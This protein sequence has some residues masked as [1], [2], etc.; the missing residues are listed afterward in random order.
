MS[1]W[2]IRIVWFAD[3]KPIVQADAEFDGCEDAE[4]MIVNAVIVANTLGQL[5]D[6]AKPRLVRNENLYDDRVTTITLNA[7]GRSRSLTV[8]DRL[9]M[10]CKEAENCAMEVMEWLTGPGME[11]FLRPSCSSSRRR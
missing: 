9:G 11:E 1:Q 5:H 2:K 8:K 3:R 6:E 4:D 10:P 7:N